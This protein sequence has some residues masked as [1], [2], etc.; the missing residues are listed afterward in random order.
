M[1]LGGEFKTP[2]TLC[3]IGKPGRHWTFNKRK[4]FKTFTHWF[5]WHLTS[6]TAESSFF[7]T[8]YMGIN[9]TPEIDCLSYVIIFTTIT[10]KGI[11]YT[12]HCAVHWSFYTKVKF[13]FLKNT[14][15]PSNIC[16]QRAQF[17]I[18]HAE[19]WG[20]VLVTVLLQSKFERWKCLSKLKSCIFG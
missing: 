6:M 15:L 10:K 18:G 12:F 3:G 17:L 14:E 1:K 9:L 8:R 4:N 19:T 13:A 20:C 11:N 7:C 16:S 5:I 2:K